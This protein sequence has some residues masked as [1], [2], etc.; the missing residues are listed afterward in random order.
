MKPLIIGHRGAAAVAPENTLVSFERALHDGADGIEFDVRI[1][2]DR[3]PVVIHDETLKRT[4]LR[5]GRIANLSSAELSE[6]DV[7][8]WFNLYRP[9]QAKMEFAGARIPLLSNVFEMLKEGEAILYVELKCVPKDRSIMAAEVA[10]LIQAHSLKS[11]TVVESFDHGA[12]AEIKRI[13]SGFRTAALFD[14]RFTQPAPSMRKM[15]DRA[16][17]CGAEEIALHH[18]LVTRKTV[19]HAARSGLRIVVWT[20][21]NT[22]WIESA[23]KDGIHAIITNNP[24]KMSARR[25]ELMKGKDEGGRRKG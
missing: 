7:G 17:F 1:A 25:S 13:D 9:L 10:K 12:I 23:I 16:K 8:T 4:A 22:D 3:L 5:K 2:R 20:V 18:S 24:A 19:E 11:R 6:I 21:D 15:I 14:R